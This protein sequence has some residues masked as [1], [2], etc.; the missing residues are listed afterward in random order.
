[1]LLSKEIS[2]IMVVLTLLLLTGFNVF[3]VLSDS[4]EMVKITVSIEILKSIIYPVVD[5]VGEVHPIVS[6][7]I[8][9][10]GFTLTPEVINIARGSDLI[11]ITGH[12]EW[13][14]ELVSQIAREKGVSEELISINTMNLDGVEILAL[15]GDKNVHGFWLLPDN[16]LMIAKEVREKLSMLKPELSGK[17]SENYERFE[18]EISGL[19][20]FLYNLSSKYGSYGRSIVI[21]FYEEQYVAEAMGLKVGAILM[22]EG[23]AVRPESLRNIYEGLKSGEYVCLIVSDIALLMEGVQKALEN[24]REETGCSIAYVLTTS[25]NGLK[26]YDAIIY[27]NAGQVYSALLSKRKAV[28]NGFNIYLIVVLVLSLVIVFETLLLIRG[29]IKL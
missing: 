11:V 21:G 6:G 7:E 20:A 27:Y 28:S 12:M 29:R 18:R 23:G 5:G 3:I 17:L 19:K 8:D 4:S 1:M 2:A 26:D 24:I 16:A 9:P 25:A 10:H 13:E 14:E 15:N 22:G